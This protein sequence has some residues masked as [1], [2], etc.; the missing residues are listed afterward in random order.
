[1]I[2]FKASSITGEDDLSRVQKTPQIV[3]YNNL[4]IQATSLFSSSSSSSS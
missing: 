2:I 1:M 3:I 4:V